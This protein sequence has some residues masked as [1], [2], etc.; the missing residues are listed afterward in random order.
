ML[1]ERWRAPWG[2][3]SPTCTGT[4]GS[5]TW[6]STGNRHRAL[7]LSADPG[8]RALT[9]GS[10]YRHRALTL[11]ADTGNRALTE[12][13]HGVAVPGPTG[14]PGTG[15]RV[16]TLGTGTGPWALTL[17]TNIKYRHQGLG[18]GIEH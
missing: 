4:R 8:S 10:G 6:V 9:P 13:L 3:R 18:T 16:P 15:Y 12:H 11:S 7:I 14:A 2:R 17:G 5:D 1:R